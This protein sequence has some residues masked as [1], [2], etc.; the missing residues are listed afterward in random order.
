M[1]FGA[2][3][4]LILGLCLALGLMAGPA[5]ADDDTPYTVSKIDVDVTAKNAV[6][7]KAK[8]MAD[9]Q[10]RGIDTVLRRVVPFSF[11]AKL[12]DLQPQQVETLVNGMAIRKEQYSTT[13]YIATLDVI[14]NEQGVKE[15]LTSL[16]I[17]T[18]EE[19]APMISVLPLVIDGNKVK[20]VNEPWRQA[21][22]DLDLTHGLTPANVLQPRPEL[23]AGMVRAVLAGDAGAF[24]AVQRDYGS[25]P[26]IIAVGQKVEGGRFVTRLAGTDGVG[27][28]NYG[29]S[30]KLSG[31]APKAAQDAASFAYAVLENRWKATRAAPDPV[32]APVNY[33]EGGTPPP[34]AAPQQGEPGRLVTAVVVFAGLKEWQQIRGRLAQVPGLQRLEVNSLSARTASITFDYAGSLGH[35]Q[36]VLGQSGFSFE[37]R[38]EAFVL[39][40]R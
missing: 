25:A 23:E 19:R 36:Q 26:L 5:Q 12:P 29:R 34:Q 38:E 2:S 14:F 11:S 33:E 13:R 40:A 17:P 35:L 16:G 27:R 32:A 21:W 20:S 7:A 6:A 30:D 10:K 9:A 28:I 22:L 24:A 31:T 18:S 8:A 3:K 4:G 39:R 1:G 37:N 15:L